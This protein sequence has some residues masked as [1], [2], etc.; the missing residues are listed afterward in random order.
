MDAS[1]FIHPDDL[2]AQ[3][4]LEAI[5]MASSIMKTVLKFGW[6]SLFYGMN[7]AQ[8][9]RLSPKQ[10]PEIYNLLPPICKQ[11]EIEEPEFYL[12]M[13]PIPNAYS[14]GDT[15]RFISVTSGLIEHM[16]TDEIRAVI[17]HEC[18]HL[19]C[20]HTLYHNVAQFI[21]QG[22]AKNVDLTSTIEPIY[23]ALMY[24]ERKGEL[25]C[26]RVGAYVAGNDAMISALTRL[27]GGPES[28]T[29]HLNIEEFVRQA[30]IY[31]GIRTDGFWNRTLQTSIVLAQNHPFV[32]TRVRELLNWAE[33]D[34]Y[35][36]LLHQQNLCPKCHKPIMQDW[37]FCQHCGRKLK[38]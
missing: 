35:A 37:I 29:K 32:A 11:L 9:V 7:M 5:P 27:A 30:D 12:E 36:T 23:Y 15:H 14:M 24:W 3:Q 18:G 25:S 2:A 21:L 19:V 6:E 16:S 20:R 10:L 8:H 31:D 28:I 26:D 38:I 22:L 4:A 17:G 34:E 33:T 1:K 13:N